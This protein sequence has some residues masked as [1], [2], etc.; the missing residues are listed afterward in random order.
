MHRDSNPASHIWELTEHDHAT[1]AYYLYLQSIEFVS[2]V[3]DSIGVS[4]AENAFLHLSRS[5]TRLT[6]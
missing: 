3:G 2:R 1:L 6:S 4:E 5:Y